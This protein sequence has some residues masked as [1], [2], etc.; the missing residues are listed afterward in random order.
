MK[1]SRKFITKTLIMMVTGFIIGVGI[2]ICELSGFGADP[3]TVYYQGVSKFFNISYSLV[4]M[5]S[6]IV[7]VL[8]GGI[9]YPRVL[10]I[11]TILIP[12]LMSAGVEVSLSLLTR[13]EDFIS[14][15]ILLAIG[16][17]V[18]SI[19]VGFLIACQVGN[20][21]YDSMVLGIAHKSK[22]AYYVA[23][24]FVDAIFLV[25]GLSFGGVPTFSTIFC[26]LFLG[27]LITFFYDIAYERFNFKCFIEA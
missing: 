5:L 20:S 7:M 3:I 17:L 27:K 24:W 8:I 15:L 4:T 23:R 22:K 6:G 14:R 1:L 2:G 21:P 19:S 13:S 26:F 12:F 18:I 25:V 11:G 9:L 10:G 16:L